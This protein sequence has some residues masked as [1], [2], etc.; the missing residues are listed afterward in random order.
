M[1]ATIASAHSHVA[2][3]RGATDDPA[4]SE[5]LKLLYAVISFEDGDEPNWHGLE[6][7]FSTHAR[8]TRITP[9][10]ID[11]LDPSAFLAMTRNLI[12]VGAYTGFYEFEVARNVEQFGDIAQVWSLYETR[13]NKDA[14]EALGRGINSIQ[15]IRDGGTWRVL[16]L[17][18]D[19][20]HADSLPSIDVSSGGQVH[21]QG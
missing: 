17:L 18:W 19:E 15:L 7:L 10:G 3:L 20:T 16:G 11:H 6:K 13:R 8:I 1:S 5:L 2:R 12:E 4:I 14:R 21:G 9:E